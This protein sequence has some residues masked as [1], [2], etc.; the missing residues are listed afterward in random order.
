MS[1]LGIDVGTTGCKVAAFSVDGKLL[2]SAYREYDLRRDRPGHAELD[3]P[4]VW[5]RIGDCIGEATAQLPPSDASEAISVASLGEAMVPVD[6]D[7]NVL[8]RSILNVDARGNE[9]LPQ[10]RASMSDAELFSLNGNPWGE[11]YGATKL[12]WLRERQPELYDRTDWFLHWGSF[13]AF[14]LGAEP[15]VDYSLAN[16]SLL[17]DL[18]QGSWSPRLLEL[19]GLDQSKL[20]AT[21]PSGTVIG[22]VSRAAAAAYG[23][24][25]GIPIVSGAHDQ[26]ANA[27]GC[28]A[29]HDRTALYGMGTF[30]TIAPVYS[31][32]RPPE[33]MLALGLN[34]EHHAAPGLFLSFIFH[35]G[36]SI[37]KWYRDLLSAGSTE[38]GRG[39]Y[40]ELFAGL[41]DRPSGLLLLPHFVPMGPPD[42][43]SD[44][45]GLIVG[46]TTETN[47]SSILQ[48]IVEGNAFALNLVFDRLSEAGIE[49]E[50]IRVVGGGSRSNAAVQIN[51][52][53]FGKPLTR[54]DVVEA[55]ALGAAILAGTAIGRYGSIAEAVD[56]MIRPG[57]TFE[58]HPQKVEQYREAFELYKETRGQMGDL[59][60]RWTAFA[61]GVSQ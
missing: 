35:M 61:V 24:P 43:V 28:G 27:T 47:R 3:V 10:L 1:L 21:V 44:Q 42:F 39:T 31:T 52:N 40:S 36:G 48:A 34:T 4:E 20:P 51:A 41:T 46:L 11:Q 7:R 54:P 5:S 8:G 29:I 17:F 60:R 57:R 55:G 14:M 37:V 19:C 49:P 50:S 12:M 16:R 58:P 13:V 53:I 45:S 22:S 30:P 56:T 6:R 9:Y 38:E 32:P 2:S 59:L 23:L 33:A 25:A 18:N 15:R 26:C